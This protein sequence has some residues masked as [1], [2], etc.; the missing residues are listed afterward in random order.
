MELSENATKIKEKLFATTSEAD[1]AFNELLNLQKGVDNVIYTGLSFLDENLIGG[2][3]NKLIF[4]G[5]R[6][7]Q[8]KSHNAATILKNLFSEEI[9]PNQKIQALRLNLEMVTQ[10]LLLRAL[11]PA[12]NK[13][14]KSIISQEFTPSELVKAEEVLNEF[15]DPRILD[16]SKAVK[17]NDLKD[18]L[19]AFRVGVWEKD[20]AEYI[21]LGKPK[22]FKKT[23]KVVI[24][25]HLHVYDS[26]E[27]IDNVLQICNEYKMIDKD[28]S[29]I[30]YFQFNRTIEDVW[31]E[32]KE[33]KGHNFNMLPSSKY[34]YL[35]DL[36]MQYADIVMS[37]TIPQVIG[38][39]SFASV[40]KE[41]C[42]HLK[43]HFLEDGKEGNYVKLKALNRIYYDFL[44]IRMNDSF[45]DP[46]LFCEILDPSKEETVN[47]IY[48]ENQTPS[49]APP[50]FNS[51]PPTFFSDALNNAK[52][53]EF[54]DQP[55]F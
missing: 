1:D 33:K 23:K 25:D 16:F 24:V 38:L 27:S 15:K 41:R 43:D 14:L 22:G 30:F 39:E 36:L 21:R 20:N 48:Q 7:S 5:S 40:H 35:T 8:G 51:H 28:L 52:G 9:N 2:L 44:K 31:R 45:D 6:P 3:C 37:L 42:S 26:K 12:L 4:I 47:K 32:S 55:P 17:G 49:I 13:S 19:D 10:S 54:E 46:R 29:F 18:L 50:Q 34:I 53:V 11:K